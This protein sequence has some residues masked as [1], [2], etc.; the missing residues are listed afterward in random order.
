MMKEMILEIE[1][2]IE[3]ISK[4]K[5]K[6]RI[7]DCAQA[8]DNDSKA[9]VNHSKIGDMPCINLMLPNKSGST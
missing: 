8:W 9:V 7:P 2:E 1:K 4:R 6:P 5:I 3:I